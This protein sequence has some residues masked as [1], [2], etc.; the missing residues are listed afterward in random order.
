MQDFS[1]DFPDISRM[2]ALL[3]GS[4]FGEFPRVPESLLQQADGMMRRDIP[5]LM[6]RIPAEQ[7]VNDVK[8]ESGAPPP[9]G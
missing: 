1:G 4:D 8:D 9:A 7:S 3:E 2:K 6:K 5:A